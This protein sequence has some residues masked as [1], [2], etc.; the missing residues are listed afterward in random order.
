MTTWI[1]QSPFHGLSPY[2]Q[3]DGIWIPS[4]NKHRV[5]EL[6]GVEYWVAPDKGR[7]PEHNV[8]PFDSLDAAK[9]CYETLEP[10]R[11]QE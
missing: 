11:D 3:W 1:S 4:G 7:P 10:W 6:H 9:A 2:M 5:V 8:G